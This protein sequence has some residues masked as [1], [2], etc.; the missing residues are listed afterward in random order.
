MSQPAIPTTPSSPAVE[1][2]SI[3]LTEV[4][5]G[6]LDIEHKLAV[7]EALAIL[8]EVT[9]PYPPLPPASRVAPPSEGIPRALA[10]LREAI[11]HARS[12]EEA[13]R[14]AMAARALLELDPLSGAA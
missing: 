1:A 7:A 10:F 12:T 11:E 6:R 14:C 13:G 5:A 8:S 4:L 3:T 2:A 9:P